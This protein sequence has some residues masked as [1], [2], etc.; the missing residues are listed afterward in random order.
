[1]RIFAKGFSL[2]VGDDFAVVSDMSS[3]ENVD[4][5]RICGELDRV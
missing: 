5:E 3:E 1:M 4:F 2:G